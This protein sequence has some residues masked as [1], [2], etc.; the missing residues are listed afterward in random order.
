[1]RYL[2]VEFVT[3]TAVEDEYSRAMLSKQPGKGS[4]QSVPNWRFDF[5]FRLTALF[6]LV[7]QSTLKKWYVV[8]GKLILRVKITDKLYLRKSGSRSSAS[9]RS[10]TKLYVVPEELM[11]HMESGADEAAKA[12]ASSISEIGPRGL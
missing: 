1:M 2:P 5:R 8:S 3:L 12:D 10:L 4:R 6:L 7:L 11:V 9:S